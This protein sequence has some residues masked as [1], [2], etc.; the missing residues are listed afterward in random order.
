[1]CACIGEH[2]T[3]VDIGDCSTVY[4]EKVI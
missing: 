3:W 2:C 1:L 4:T